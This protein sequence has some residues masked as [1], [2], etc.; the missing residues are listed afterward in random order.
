M[1]S[2]RH[3][4]SEDLTAMIALSVTPMVERLLQAGPEPMHQMLMCAA[5][6]HWHDDHDAACAVYA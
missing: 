3:Q 5:A 2:P 4:S 6:G 1:V